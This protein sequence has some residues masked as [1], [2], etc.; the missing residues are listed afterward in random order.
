MDSTA[1]LKSDYL[2]GLADRLTLPMR[3]KGSSREDWQQWRRK[4][5]RCLRR[6][7]GPFPEPPALEV[8]ELEAVE[9]P[10]HV[11]RKIL[12]NSEADVWVPAW[13]LVPRGTAS[14]G[15]RPAVLCAHGHGLNGKDNVAGL[16]NSTGSAEEIERY[17]YDYGLSLVRMGFVVIAPDWRSFGERIAYT[18]SQSGRDWCES[19]ANCA[20]LF[21]Y[22]LLT[23][24]VHDARRAIDVL[25]T[26]ETVDRRRIGCVGFSY[27]GRLM[28]FVAA[29]DRRVKATVISGALNTFVD[30]VLINLGSCGSQIVHGLLRHGDMPEV[31]GLLAPRHLFFE[32]GTQDPE[33]SAEDYYDRVRRVYTAA[34]ARHKLCLRV[35]EGGHVFEGKHSLPWLKRCL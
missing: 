22:N 19:H 12:Y 15:K 29:L 18:A 6:V 32:K 17:K 23:L 21:G 14:D 2:H 25:E 7:M 26:L 8:R 13:I 4:W 28:T 10:D 30:R 1:S 5:A 33:P 35:F 31:A 27:G 3:F 9:S 20:S 24:N 16:R 34:G 11:R